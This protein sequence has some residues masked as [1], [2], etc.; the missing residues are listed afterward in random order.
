[1]LAYGAEHAFRGWILTGHEKLRVGVIVDEE[2]QT[3]GRLGLLQP[4]GQ[5]LCLGSITLRFALE[6]LGARIC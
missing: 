6:V 5:H 1:M 2:L 3:L 4:C